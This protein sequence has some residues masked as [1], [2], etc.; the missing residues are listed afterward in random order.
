M[1]KLFGVPRTF[2][3]DC[4]IGL[5]LSLLKIWSIMQLISPWCEAQF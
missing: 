4:S 2:G 5:V 3:R 1:D